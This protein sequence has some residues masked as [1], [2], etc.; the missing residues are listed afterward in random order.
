[1][2]EDK[3]VV[4][5]DQQQWLELEEI[6]MENDREAALRFLKQYVYDVIDKKQRK[7][8]QREV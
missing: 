6:L 3:Y 5:F 7:Q 8:L 4:T 1:M 2:P